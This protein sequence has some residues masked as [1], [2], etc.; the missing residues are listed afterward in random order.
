MIHYHKLGGIRWITIGRFGKAWVRLSWYCR[1][2][3]KPKE[4]N[5]IPLRKA[6]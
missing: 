4:S 6:Q 2:K 5:V 1:P 3:A